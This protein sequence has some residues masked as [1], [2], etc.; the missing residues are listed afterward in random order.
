MAGDFVTLHIHLAS[1]SDIS[2]S[3]ETSEEAEEVAK[4][5]HAAI[6]EE[7]KPH[8]H[9]IDTTLVFTGAVSAIEVL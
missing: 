3:Y 8:W 2:L 6:E 4:A 7:G 9:M 1:G 5:L